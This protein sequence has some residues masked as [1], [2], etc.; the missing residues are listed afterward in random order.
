M[1]NEFG[2]SMDNGNKLKWIIGTHGNWK[3]S[4]FRGPFWSYQLNS[5]TNSAYSPQKWAKWAELVVLFS[6]QLQNSHHNLDFFFFNCHVSRLFIWAYFYCPLGTPIFQISLIYDFIG[7]PK[8]V[9]M[10]IEKIKILGAVLELPP[11]WAALSIW[12]IY[13]KI[14]QNGLNW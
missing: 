1:S 4:K 13:Q 10:A 5:T 6:W 8:S 12:P 3:K 7:C 9:H 14:G 11:T 2:H